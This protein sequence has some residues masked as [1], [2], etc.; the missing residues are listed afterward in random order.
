MS[1]IALPLLTTVDLHAADQTVGW[2]VG[3]NALLQIPFMLGFGL[4]ASRYGNTKIMKAAGVF[5]VLYFIISAGADSAW[6]LAACQILNA[7]YVSIVLGVGLNY[8]QELM[9]EAPGTATTMYSNATT[10]GMMLGGFMAGSIGEWMG[11]RAIFI[12]CA[13]LAGLGFMLINSTYLL[14]HNKASRKKAETF[15]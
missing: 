11:N 14:S 9:P 5:G 8:C 7:S 3:L 2:L 6:Q 10:I 13:A 15:T 1:G 4:L 12:A